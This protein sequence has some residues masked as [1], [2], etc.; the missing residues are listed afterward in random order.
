MGDKTREK[1]KA[2]KK[3]DGAKPAKAARPARAE[4]TESAA[5]PHTPPLGA[6]PLAAGAVADMAALTAEQRMAIEK[7]ST[8][9][10]RAALTAQ[11][12]IAEMALRQADRPAAL[13]P[14]SPPSRTG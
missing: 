12:A 13:S 7:L 2:E 6:S 8:N 11:G 3:A 9:L 1:K 10:A 4:R 5:A 14:A